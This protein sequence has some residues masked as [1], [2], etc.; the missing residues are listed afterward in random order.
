M[1]KI[2]FVGI[3]FYV[4]GICYISDWIIFINNNDDLYDDFPTLKEKYIER[5]PDFAKPLIY[6]NPQPAAII[7]AIFFVTSG[8]I[9]IRSNSI[10]F[11][12]LAI[13]SFI[14]SAWNLLSII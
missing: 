4:L 13:T 8:Y 9:F 11:K 7:C 6:L 3:I 1:R 10:F 12:I 14:F 2:N 5:F